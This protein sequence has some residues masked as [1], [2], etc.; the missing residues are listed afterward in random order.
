MKRLLYATA[1]ALLLLPGS[2][3]AQMEAVIDLLQ[4]G[5]ADSAQAMIRSLQGRLAA[6]EIQFLRA[7]AEVDG[8][9]AVAAYEALLIDSPPIRLHRLHPAKAGSGLLRPSG[10]PNR[11]LPL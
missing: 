6:D 9:Q 7:L 1:V 2:L 11:P 3:F 4:N 8:S 10:L 5:Q